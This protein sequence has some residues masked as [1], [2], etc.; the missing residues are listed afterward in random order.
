MKE[1][2]LTELSQILK[3]DFT[4]SDTLIDVRT[5]EECEEK[6]IQGARNIPLYEIQE[7]AEELKQFNRIF[8]CC[9][10]GVRSR[11]AGEYL[12]QLGVKGLFSVKGSIE[13]WEAVGLPIKS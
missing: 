12:S 4:A 10:A 7:H 6:Q 5:P 13:D 3:K 1:I 11:I 8:L 9:K 2:L